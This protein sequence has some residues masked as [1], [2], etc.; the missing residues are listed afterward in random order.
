MRTRALTV[1]EINS[2]LIEKG[3]KGCSGVKLISSENKWEAD[4][5]CFSEDKKTGRSFCGL[6]KKAGTCM[7]IRTETYVKMKNADKKEFQ[8]IIENLPNAI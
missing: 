8:K 5:I 7:L 3:Y 2:I 6:Y 1:S 4:S